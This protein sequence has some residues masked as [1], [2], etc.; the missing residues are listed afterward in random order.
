MMNISEFERM[1]PRETYRKIQG[2][3]YKYERLLEAK[4]QLM[5]L[6][7]ALLVEVYTSILNDL[8]SIQRSFTSGD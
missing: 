1:K 8:K 2:A 3:I 7:D 5:D 4:S 6:K